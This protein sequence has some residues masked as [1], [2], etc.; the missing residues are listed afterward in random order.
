MIRREL[1]EK[2]CEEN[3]D[4]LRQDVAK[5]VVAFFDRITAQLGNGGRVEL[6]GFGAFFTKERGPRSGRNPMTGVPYSKAPHSVPRFRVSPLLAREMI[7]PK[8]CDADR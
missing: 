8:Q 1:I 6:R 3:P 5:A 4:I 7:S 2:L